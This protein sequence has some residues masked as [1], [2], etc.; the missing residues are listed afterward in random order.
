MERQELE[1]KFGQ[2]WNTTELQ[3]D[4]NVESFFR[5]P[6]F[7]NSYVVARRKVDNVK[8]V[9]EFQHRPRYYWSFL[10]TK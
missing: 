10:D 2:V 1:E 6:L 8:G 9:L 4:Y 5:D 7:G 3:E